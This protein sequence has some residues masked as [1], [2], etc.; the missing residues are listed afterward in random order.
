MNWWKK[1]T[2][3]S[4]GMLFLVLGE[5]MRECRRFRVTHYTPGASEKNPG[6]PAERRI[7]F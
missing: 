6:S 3:S 2:L 4:V 1:L 5:G 7:V